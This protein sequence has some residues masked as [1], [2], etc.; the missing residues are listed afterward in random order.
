M[1]TEEK[2]LVK[3]TKSKIDFNELLRLW[4]QINGMIDDSDFVFDVEDGK[5]GY[6]DACSFSYPNFDKFVKENLEKEML[7]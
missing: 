5:W 3:M 4:L 6:I 2:G 1:E 7:K